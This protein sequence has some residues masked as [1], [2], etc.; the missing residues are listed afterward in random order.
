[1]YQT[2]SLTGSADAL[3]VHLDGAITNG[4]ASPSR[5][6]REKAF[7]EEGPQAVGAFPGA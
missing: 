4:N 6:H 2:R 1:M 3:A 7:R 5:E